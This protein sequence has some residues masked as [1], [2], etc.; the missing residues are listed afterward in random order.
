MVMAS[1]ID[2]LVPVDD[3]LTEL[4]DYKDTLEQRAI[5]EDST[6]TFSRVEMSRRGS[7]MVNTDS[8][9]ED[10]LVNSDDPPAVQDDL[11]D[12]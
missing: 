6:G 2:Y 8:R 7:F 11:V 9:H 3:L 5:R 10:L 4:L 1:Q 12:A